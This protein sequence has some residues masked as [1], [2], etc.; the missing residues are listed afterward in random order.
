MKKTTFA[1]VAGMLV[2]PLTIADELTD[3]VRGL[4]SDVPVG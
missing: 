1:L 4:S 2:A 3:A